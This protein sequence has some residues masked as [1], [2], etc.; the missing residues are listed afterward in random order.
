MRMFWS[1]IA[2]IDVKVRNYGIYFLKNVEFEQKRLIFS[3]K[4]KDF[5]LDNYN[6]VYHNIKG[7]RTYDI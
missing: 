3:K 2:R 6:S 4:K 5:L 7:I 1:G